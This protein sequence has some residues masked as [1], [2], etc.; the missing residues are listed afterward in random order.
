M[1]YEQRDN[2]GS[3]FIN[4]RKEKDSHPDFKGSIQVDGSDYWL[5]IWTKNGAK[6]EF[7]S[8]SVSPK[9]AKPSNNQ[10]RPITQGTSSL[11]KKS[12]PVSNADALDDD[13]PF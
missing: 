4:D 1:A 10:A 2:S 3:F 9:E 13:L 12:A 6:G 8:V 5:S 11:S 7:W